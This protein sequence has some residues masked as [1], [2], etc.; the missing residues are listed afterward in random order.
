MW[1][2][3]HYPPRRIELELQRTSKQWDLILT[4]D[5]DMDQYYRRE[6]AYD[7]RILSLGY[8]RDDVLVGP[9]RQQIRTETRHRLGIAP[10]QRAVLYAPT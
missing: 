7:G 10:G 5:P 1:D 6:Y 3:K 2:A 4:P 8:P 9:D